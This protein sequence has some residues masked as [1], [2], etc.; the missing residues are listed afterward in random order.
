M[1]EKWRMKKLGGS[2]A[3]VVLHEAHEVKN[4]SRTG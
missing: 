3:L 1:R 4:C 2:S